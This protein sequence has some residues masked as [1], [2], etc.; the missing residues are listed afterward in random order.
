MNNVR[1]RT[2][3]GKPT[4]VK[5]DGKWKRALT[6]EQER[7]AIKEF[8]EFF[9]QEIF[10]AQFNEDKSRLAGKQLNLIRNTCEYLY[11]LADDDEKQLNKEDEAD[12]L[13]QD[14]K[15]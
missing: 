5:I 1:R 8:A 4:L 3:E 14:Y 13:Q 9:I 2:A 15:G 12:E 11:R 10:I 6:D 7:Q